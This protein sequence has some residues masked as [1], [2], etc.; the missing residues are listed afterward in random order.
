MSRDMTIPYTEEE[1][2][3]AKA[4]FRS[5][6]SYTEQISSKDIPRFHKALGWPSSPAQFQTYINYWDSFYGGVASL[7][8][9]IQVLRVI[10]DSVALMRDRVTACDLDGDGCVDPKEFKLLLKYLMIHDPNVKSTSFETFLEEA[11]TNK[12]GRV[13][14]EECT[15]W[16]QKCLQRKWLHFY[17]KL[18]RT[19]EFLFKILLSLNLLNKS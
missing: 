8:Q 2:E 16:V 1:L 14:I 4:I 9:M 12:D 17:H 18:Y 3:E 10:H 6:P 13:S 19:A 11:D 15:E 5:M 7:S